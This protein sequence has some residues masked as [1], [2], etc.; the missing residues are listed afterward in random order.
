MAR[1]TASTPKNSKTVQRAGK[2]A[3]DEKADTAGDDVPERVEHAV[4]G[5]SQGDCRLAVSLDHQVCVL[6]DFPQCFEGQSQDEPGARP[7]LSH[8]RV[9]QREQEKSV[10]DVGEA[11][12]V[13][14]ML[15]VMGAVNVAG[16]G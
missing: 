16:P 14:E 11:V 3:G 2:R 12:G 13:E 9:E 5:I 6:D 15:R 4:T 1:S 10:Q 7:Q 8:Q